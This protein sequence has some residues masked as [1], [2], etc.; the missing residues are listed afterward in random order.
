MAKAT[1]NGQDERAL[2]LNRIANATFELNAMV[3][4]ATL[5][6]TNLIRRLLDERR[7]IDDECGYPK[8]ITADQYKIL[9]DRESIATRV[10]QVWP[11][12]CWKVTPELFEDEDPN[13]ETEFE[14][15][16]KGL[17]KNLRG[18]SWFEGEE[19]NP[20]WEW[21]ERIDELSGVG[22][23]GVLLIGFND[24]QKDMSQPVVP[25]P[26]MEILYIRAFDESLVDILNYEMDK[27]SPRYG[28]PN[29]YLVTLNDPND[30][31]S[32]SGTGLQLAT[33]R[34]H[35]SRVIHVAD[36]LG[37]SEIF[38]VPRI[39]PVYNR[40]YDLRKLYGGSAEM[41]WQGA[42]PGIMFEQMPQAADIEVGDDMKEAIEKYMN[43]LQ[44]YLALE[45]FS[46]KSL[47]PQVADPSAHIDK[48]IDAICIQL[49]IP[50]RIFTG[51]ERGELASSQDDSTWN[52]RVAFRQQQY[53]TPRLIVPFVDRLIQMGA[54]PE[55][56]Q[57]FVKWPDLDKQTDL[58]KTTV[59]AKMTEALVKYVSGNGDAVV[60]PMA[61]L[62][63]VM[64]IDKET[65]QSIIDATVAYHE[66][67]I[68]EQEEEEDEL[69]LAMRG[70]DLEFKKAEVDQLRGGGNADTDEK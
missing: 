14:L 12:E 23:Y 30:Q 17:G 2:A 51:S 4:N 47:A 28:L 68:L 44:R 19:G 57:Y 13:T 58:E 55:P 11:R 50:K 65:A 52:D 39:R 60:E 42:F 29:Q 37:S 70:Q 9:Y 21:L 61:W 48:Q 8:D 16:W 64:G 32:G 53:V 7:D 27:A 49:A 22:A 33:L 1:N 56:K 18:G 15:A 20:L 35:W 31:L 67:P 41:F 59:G 38:G 36:N 3:H 25:R 54:L 40:C 34:V 62:T 45:G 10:V 5:T 24:G 6:R 63:H 46:A 66:D 69:D 43:S 26:G